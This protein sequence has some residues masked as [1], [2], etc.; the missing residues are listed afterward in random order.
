MGICWEPVWFLLVSNLHIS[1]A[2]MSN[3]FIRPLKL[4]K[5][6]LAFSVTQILV[7]LQIAELGIGQKT[8]AGQ[9]CLKK[10]QRREMFL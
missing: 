1:K 8:C 5:H 3:T 6:K 4:Y 9:A 7:R 2:W 10:N